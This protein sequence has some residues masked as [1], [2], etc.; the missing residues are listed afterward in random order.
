M[1]YLFP[2][3]QSASGIWSLK[4]YKN[5]IITGNFPTASGAG[6]RAMF[7][8]GSTPGSDN[9]KM[10]D[11]V[12]VS[13]TGNAADFGDIGQ[14][15]TS[16][17]GAAGNSYRSIVSGG[18]TGVP[19]TM[20]YVTPS[21]TGNAADFGDMTVGRTQ[22]IST[23]NT[24]RL[25]NMGG[26][27][28]SI[29][30]VIDYV[31]IASEG[32]AIDFGDLTGNTR[33][34]PQGSIATPTRGTFAGG[35]TP[36]HTNV[37]Q[38]MQF[39]TTG[40][41]TD[42]GDLTAVRSQQAGHSSPTRGMVMTGF[43]D[44][45]ANVTLNII[46]YIEL[47]SLGNAV[48]FGDASAT[49]SS[50]AG[51][52]NLTRAMRG[53]GGEGTY[54]SLPAATTIDYFTIASTGDATDFGDLVDASKGLTAASQSHGGVAISDG[55]PR[56]LD[57]WYMLPG[58]GNLVCLGPGD[59]RS[60][61]TEWLNINQKS[62]TIDW[63]DLTVIRRICAGGAD[64]IRSFMF[65]GYDVSNN[66]IDNIEMS[67]WQHKGG[68]SDW[69]DLIN[70]A[71]YNTGG[72][73]NTT[74]VIAETSSSIEYFSPTSAGNGTDFGDMTAASGARS[75]QNS[76]NDT[77]G[78]LWCGAP[79]SADT[80]VD[81]ITYITLASTGNDT[82]FGDATASRTN[83]VGTGSATRAVH[84]GGNNYPAGNLNVIEYA[85]YA[86][87]GDATDFGDLTEA[88]TDHDAA[89]NSTRAIWMLGNSDNDVM[90]YV[91]IASTGNATD[92]G[93]VSDKGRNAAATSNGHGGLQ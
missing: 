77:R 57:N 80:M 62:N 19:A 16:G 29:T 86:S 69:G 85:T 38:Q 60:Y 14:A 22:H 1:A 48:D 26:E 20:E 12:N 3:R 68:W 81:D 28:P 66:G 55:N 74:R 67:F 89:G 44:T 13:T 70:G 53:G 54:P 23:S 47:G 18:A 39:S 79:G 8:A 87:T 41:A 52:G 2:N 11:Y 58:D 37:I 5:Y 46:E 78:L 43:T 61:T 15:A 93:D 34:G 40:N 6:D 88:R 10:I 50:S 17:M 92:F 7:F 82:D 91:T 49:V 24:T 27:T 56:V 65:G 63:G 31:Q 84:G 76:S 72:M 64:T 75:N 51:V 9:S 59:N 35:K 42:F 33:L 4:N 21:T 83:L 90:D 73:G 25:L 32:N 30:N 45:P 36:S 71:A